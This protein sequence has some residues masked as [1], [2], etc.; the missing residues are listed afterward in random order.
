MN[1]D[2]AEAVERLQLRG[3]EAISDDVLDNILERNAPKIKPARDAAELKAHLEKKYLEPSQHF[4]TEW[5]NKLQQY[6]TGPIFTWGQPRPLSKAWGRCSGCGT[7]VLG[8]TRR[9]WDP[10]AEILTVS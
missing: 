9:I 5:L 1:D 3:G 7:S 4:S 6:V 8:M 10:Q 2:I